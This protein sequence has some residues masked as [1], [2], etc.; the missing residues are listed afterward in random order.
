MSSKAQDTL[1]PIAQ[2]GQ[3][4][5]PT[6]A[7]QLAKIL[8]IA[9]LVVLVAFGG[10]AAW[11]TNY[12]WG[13]FS[14]DAEHLDAGNLPGLAGI[15][16]DAN[17]LIVGLDQCPED[18]ALREKFGE[19]CDNPEE[20]GVVGADG[21]QRNDVN[22]L[23][24]ISEEPRKVT[25]ISF[26]RDIVADLPECTDSDGVVHEPEVER[27]NEAYSRGGL[28]C[29]AK[30][31]EQ[32]S[33]NRISIQYA[34]MTTWEGVVNMTNAIGGVEVCIENGINDY[35]TGLQLAAGTHELKGYE[36]LQ[37]L[38]VRHGVGNGGDETR[39]SNQQVYMSALAR[40]MLSGD[41]LGDLPTVSR[42][43]KTTIDNVT[44]SESLADPIEIANL[45]MAMRGV[46]LNDVKFV[47]YP[48]LPNPDNPNV[49]YV[50]DETA[51]DALWSAVL[52]NQSFEV[53]G[54]TS[55]QEAPKETDPTT[56][57]QI[58]PRTGWQID[59]ESGLLISPETGELFAAEDVPSLEEPDPGTE[60]PSAAP[61]D[62]NAPIQ[63]PPEI[64]GTTPAE[65]ICS[66][67]RGIDQ[68]HGSFED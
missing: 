5:T 68:Q 47:S 64:T 13:G 28:N 63:L 38:R 42:L 26:S 36:A 66:G 59:P 30:T 10:V 23:V 6:A 7:G 65:T 8:G 46:P 15:E 1:Q 54:K 34:A 22:L 45:A 16:G 33:G 57:N 24:H 51:A 12:L 11:A 53:T 48:L 49:N 3:Q 18:P 62:P 67:G 37:F 41:V 44:P 58:D 50:V 9:A 31:I 55:G 14:K 25:V 35:D 2:H 32:F 40:K 43:A 61:T 52:S 27:I 21:E 19:R 56:G 39:M 29:V 20:Q 60:E 4:K 17:I